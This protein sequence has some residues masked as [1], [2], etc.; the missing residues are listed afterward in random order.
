MILRA[1]ALGIIPKPIR[2]AF[3]PLP[4]LTA[5]SNEIGKIIEGDTSHG[6]RIM[7]LAVGL[8][9]YLYAKREE[10]K[11]NRIDDGEPEN[12]L[13]LEVVNI[14]IA[15]MGAL[16]GA[17][18][19]GFT[20]CDERIGALYGA[21]SAMFAL[22]SSSA[23]GFAPEL[24]TPQPEQSDTNTEPRREPIVL[25]PGQPKTVPEEYEQVGDYI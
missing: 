16:A 18:F 8:M 23:F 13:G 15:I 7:G 12:K 14:G 25:L 5:A 2:E 19:A 21:S 3:A 9:V 24:N 10:A 20:H 11:I 1:P 22:K 6:S 4:T 17:A